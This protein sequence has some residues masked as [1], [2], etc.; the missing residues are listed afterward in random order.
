MYLTLTELKGLVQA[1]ENARRDSSAPGVGFSCQEPNV[2][3]DGETFRWE[4]KPRTR[5]HVGHAYPTGEVLEEIPEDVVLPRVVQTVVAEDGTESQVT[6][7]ALGIRVSLG[8]HG[9]AYLE[10]DP[11]TYTVRCGA[12]AEMEEKGGR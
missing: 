10:I 2:G 4:P 9:R 6:A 5:H 1:L 11:E 12:C 8:V 7:P 3:P